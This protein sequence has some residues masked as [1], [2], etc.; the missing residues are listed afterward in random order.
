MSPEQAL[1]IFFEGPRSV[2]DKICEL[3]EIVRRHDGDS[4]FE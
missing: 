1:E 3:D 4:L 2:V